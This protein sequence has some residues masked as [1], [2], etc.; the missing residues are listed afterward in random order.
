MLRDPAPAKIPDITLPPQVYNEGR[1]PRPYQ[2]AVL[3]WAW[4]RNSIGLFLEMRLGKSL[5]AIKW[6]KKTSH[7][8]VII[9]PKT[10]LLAW[11][12]ELR[13]EGIDPDDASRVQLITYDLYRSQ[14]QHVDATLHNRITLIID[15]STYIKNNEAERTKCLLRLAASRRASRVAILSGLP[16]PNSFQD[17]PTQLA[18]LENGYFDG[19]DL[20]LHPLKSCKRFY[21]YLPQAYP[22]YAPTP[23]L[24][25]AVFEATEK[26]CFRL[27]RSEVGVAHEKVYK[28]IYCVMDSLTEDSYS[29]LEE[30]W[31]NPD[32]TLARWAIEK[33]TN[34][35]KI[36]ASAKIL[37]LIDYLRND[38]PNKQVIVWVKFNDFGLR[39]QNAMKDSRPTY[40][41][42]GDQTSSMRR[43]IL[44][45][46][47]VS[48]NGLMIAQMK[49]GKFGLNMSHCDTAIYVNQTYDLEDRIQSEDRIV[50]P[51]Q[52]NPT[53]I[54]FIFP[55]TIEEHIWEAMSTKYK[56]AQEIMQRISRS[57]TIKALKGIPT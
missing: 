39:I 16:N 13:A 27:T 41:L 37:P 2:E 3:K 6:A 48:Q 54:D 53:I 10:A 43:D 57:L 55:D 32:G 19:E 34:L 33:E 18:C 56:D 1:T 38:I 30:D 42:K 35:Q 7:Q 36:L 45:N 14:R 12:R 31:I 8:I 26:Y 29:M 23:R 51:G 17:L 22:P 40:F 21:K 15:E 52:R 9:A 50:D 49:C 25:T 46:F 24:R 47:E 20:S 4:N 11:A 44:N 28:P 5:I